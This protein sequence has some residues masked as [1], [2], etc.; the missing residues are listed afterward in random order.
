M[1]NLLSYQWRE[2]AAA[3]SYRAGVSLHGHTNRSHEGLYFIVEYASRRPLLRWALAAK[4]KKAQTKGSI[5]VDFFNS[6]LD[7]PADAPFRL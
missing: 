5:T 1:Q 3:K 4:E 7:A 6:Y 2:P